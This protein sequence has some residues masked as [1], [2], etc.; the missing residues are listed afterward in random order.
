MKKLLISLLIAAFSVSN[1]RADEP[2]MQRFVD[3]MRELY[4]ISEL[5]KNTLSPSPAGYARA[6]SDYM[7]EYYMDPHM[8]WVL[9]ETSQRAKNSSYCSSWLKL[10]LVNYTVA[11]NDFAEAYGGEYPMPPS[12]AAVHQSP[13]RVIIIERKAA[14]IPERFTNKRETGADY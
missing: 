14:P 4:K 9:P 10:R 6:I 13:S 12:L 2:I 8:H 7:K 3:S 1:A 5:C 11:R